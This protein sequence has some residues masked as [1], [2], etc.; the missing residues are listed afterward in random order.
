MQ[1]A[2]ATEA[3]Q[4]GV[5]GYTWYLIVPFTLRTEMHKAPEADRPLRGSWLGSCEKFEI[6][7]VPSGNDADLQAD[8]HM[9]PRLLVSPV[10]VFADRA[11]RTL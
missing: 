10:H 2:W 3:Y 8:R 7:I 5:V 9:S 6:Q 1:Q 4:L 11:G